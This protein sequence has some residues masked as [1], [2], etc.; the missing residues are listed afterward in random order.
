MGKGYRISVTLG[1]YITYNLIYDPKILI[2]SFRY[3]KKPL[4]S[5][6]QSTLYIP[7]FVI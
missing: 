2:A 3:F 6:P 7:L 1:V 4:L 5:T